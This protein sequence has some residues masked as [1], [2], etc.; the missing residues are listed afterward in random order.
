MRG[1]VPVVLPCPMVCICEP[2]NSLPYLAKL[3][4]VSFC[5]VSLGAQLIQWMK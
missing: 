4:Q 1:F 5:H 3:V 2:I